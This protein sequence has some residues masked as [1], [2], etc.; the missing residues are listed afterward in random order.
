MKR[1]GNSNFF[2]TNY[3]TA[4]L[5]W[6]ITLRSISAVAATII[7]AIILSFAI[8][9]WILICNYEVSNVKTTKLTIVNKFNFYVIFVQ[10]A[11]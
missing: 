9:H 11:C 10:I 5:V 3:F 2:A 4:Q 7:T 8:L 1:K 6:L